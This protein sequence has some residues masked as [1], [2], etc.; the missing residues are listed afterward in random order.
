MERLVDFYNPAL[1]DTCFEAILFTW[2]AHQDDFVLGKLVVHLA[3]LCIVLEKKLK[4]YSVLGLNSDQKQT[5]E[6]H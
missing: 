5:H 3:L 6:S 2:P 1:M 4:K